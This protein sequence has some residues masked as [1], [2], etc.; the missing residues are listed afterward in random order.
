MTVTIFQ[1]VSFMLPVFVVLGIAHQLRTK[2]ITSS[3]DAQLQ[4]LEIDSSTEIAVAK[5]S[6]E[7]L[8]ANIKKVEEEKNSLLERVT[9]SNEQAQLKEVEIAK[10]EEKLNQLETRSEEYK[11]QQSNMQDLQ[12]LHTKSK[13]DA[14]K[15]LDRSNYLEKQVDELKTLLSAKE[16]DIEQKNER[17]R[18][19]ESDL[20]GV[21]NKT[22]AEKKAQEDQLK[23][24]NDSE[25][26]LS[27][28][29][30]NLANKIFE[31][32]AESLKSQSKETLEATLSPLRTALTDFKSQVQNSY[33]NEALERRSL[34]QEIV[35]LKDLN[36]SMTK[37]AANLTSALKGDNKTQGTWG[38]MILD[39]I[40]Q[41]SGLRQG[42]E[43][44]IQCSH[45]DEDG[46]LRKPDVIV[47]LPDNKDVIIDSKVVLKHYEQ[48]C[49]AQTDAERE[50]A[51]RGHKAAIKSHIKL[52]SE[53]K[54]EDLKGV[55]TLD[56]VLMFIPIEPALHLALQHDG[57]LFE[58]ALDKNIMLVSP[59]NLH[60]AL[61]TIQNIWRYEH[62]TQNA[63]QIATK[64]GALYDK[65]VGFM[66]DMNKIGRGINQVGTAYNEA[67][68]KLSEGRGNL[69]NQANAFLELGV[70]PKKSLP[71]LDNSYR[72]PECLTL[73]H[74]AEKVA[75]TN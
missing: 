52:L 49:S 74:D 12:A 47:H 48:F 36:L 3:C 14:A 41:Q 58:E 21:T 35:S 37:E 10:L 23:L 73:D 60:V 65:F 53:K 44:D 5:E 63:Q 62:Q 64:A 39:T 71:D 33:Q 42:H 22:A 6:V 11:L 55:N 61:R 28:Q 56:Y 72:T 43:Y 54:Y 75:T 17:L 2:K 51:L 32:K 31:Q 27:E 46:S 26:R 19:L 67:C 8:T 40:L 9:D 70:K 29:F 30:E 4:R 1:L 45:R 16:Q 68:K 66:E 25:R 7:R 18:D 34:K 50:I 57:S 38:E 24:L 20:A 59:A 69:K 15:F 13:E